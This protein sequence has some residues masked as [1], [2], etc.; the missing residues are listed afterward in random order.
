MLSRSSAGE[1]FK[2]LSHVQTQ[3]RQNEGKK[4]AEPRIR[5]TSSIVF[6]S[7]NPNEGMQGRIISDDRISR[8]PGYYPTNNESDPFH[9]TVAATDAGNHHLLQYTASAAKMTFLAE[10]FAPSQVAA[11]RSSMRHNQIVLD[12]TR[13]CVR[14]SPLMYSTLAYSSSCM[15]SVTGTVD[16]NKPPEYFL[17]K[18]LYAVRTN[19]PEIGERR[20]T[21]SLISVYALAIT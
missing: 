6:R 13:Q 21:W 14:D 3:R 7:D 4:N 9:S 12:R 17:G 11:S 2:I 19:L 8:L 18:A 15:A 10:A 16:P 1:R 20:D 5:Y